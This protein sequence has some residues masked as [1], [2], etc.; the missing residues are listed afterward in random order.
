[1][2]G[3]KWI[4]FGLI[5]NFCISFF[6]A[7][8]K[9]HTALEQTHQKHVISAA[10]ILNG[11]RSSGSQTPISSNIRPAHKTYSLPCFPRPH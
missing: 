7:L 5:S 6:K 1:M 2:H 11:G 9:P 4:T 10:D 8:F 3:G